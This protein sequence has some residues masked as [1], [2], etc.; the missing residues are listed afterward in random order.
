MPLRI[1]IFGSAQGSHRARE[2]IYFTSSKFDFS[3]RHLDPGF[4]ATRDRKFISRLVGFA[5]RWLDRLLCLHWF[6]VADLIYILPMAYP[7]KIEIL[8]AKLFGAKI[9]GEFYISR[10][11]TAVNDRKTCIPNSSLAR[12]LLK[13][14][15]QFVD[16][17]NH[18]LFLNCS[19]KKYYL[20][21]IGRENAAAKT[22]IA[23]LCSPENKPAV[24]PYAN[25]KSQSISLVW[26]GTYIP[27]HGLE[28]ILKAVSLLRARQCNCKLSIFGAGG[29]SPAQYQATA[30]ELGLDEF[31]R[32]H[33]G[34]TFSDG[35]LQ[36]TLIDG[37]DIAFGNFGDS[38]KAKT[39]LVN[40]IVEAASFGLPIISQPT[41]AVKEF[42][43]DGKDIL[44]AES[45]AES[46]AD[47]VAKLERDSDLSIAIGRNARLLHETTFSRDNYIRQVGGILE[48]V[49]QV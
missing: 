20:E 7:S 18:L 27:L 33:H 14:D 31:I 21:L 11:D 25:G 17:C 30:S 48:S 9:I 45:T 6:A 46:I 39:V 42:F 32:F 13:A 8:V 43:T 5:A 15:R 37:A 41:A 24:L 2:L 3:A 44:F 22:S 49:N 28:K 26:W 38:V 1:L 34:I 16:N 10:Y 12:R 47:Q 4:F 19:E 36:R 35:S 23:P 29:T 40:K